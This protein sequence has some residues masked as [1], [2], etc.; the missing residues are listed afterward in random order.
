[1]LDLNLK[2]KKKIVGVLFIV[3]TI[4]L[5]AILAQV[6]FLYKTDLFTINANIFYI[7]VLV[8]FLIVLIILYKYRRIFFRYLVFPFILFSLI[9]PLEKTIINYQIE[10][11]YAKG[12]I[13][14]KELN[15]YYTEHQTYPANLKSLFSTKEPKYFIFFLPRKYKY[16]KDDNN[17]ELSVE[18]YNGLELIYYSKYRK[19]LSHD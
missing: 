5:V 3:L 18:S 6:Y 15:N 11:S 1:M 8:F 17:F 4:F 2:N 12:E 10:Q 19:W 14:I 16:S 13:I 9:K 7:G